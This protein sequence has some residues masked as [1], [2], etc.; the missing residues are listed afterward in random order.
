M[1]LETKMLTIFLQKKLKKKK[2]RQI[3]CLENLNFD[4]LYLKT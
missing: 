4:N 3:F 1:D 2:L